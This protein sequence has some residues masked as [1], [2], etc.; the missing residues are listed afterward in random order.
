MIKNPEQVNFQV[1]KGKGSIE[2]NKNNERLS[3]LSELKIQNNVSFIFV[4][5]MLS[6]CCCYYFIAFA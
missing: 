5:F 3:Q 1:Y 6:F 2:E 4:D